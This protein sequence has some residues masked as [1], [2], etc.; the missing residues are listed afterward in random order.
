[1]IIMD[2]IGQAIHNYYFNSDKEF[3]NVDSN[4]TEDEEIDPARFFREFDEMPDLEK[5][6]LDLCRGKILDV[7][8]G[9]GCHAL[10]L[11][12]RG[13][14][15]TALEKSE[16]AVDVMLQRGVLKVLHE[17]ICR[18]KS[19][20]YDTILLLMNGAGIAGTI[21]G[22]KKLLNHLKS[23]LSQGGQILL[24]STDISYLFEEE[25]GSVWIDL[26]S[27]DY[28]GEMTYTVTYK[29]NIVA[30][31]PWLFIDFDTLSDIA[32]ECDFSCEL[33]EEGADNDFL[34]KLS[35]I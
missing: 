31:F 24:D 33:V 21:G 27:G 19:D 16:M 29:K 6:A 14:D 8:A 4:Y 25:D 28:Y 2:P 9:A 1:M 32:A 5:T 11:Q 35:N 34:A 18:F 26:A 3:L 30:T 13:F 15:V 23:L 7:G 20:N 12:T 17:D 10:E 22:L